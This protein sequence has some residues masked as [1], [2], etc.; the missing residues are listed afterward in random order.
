[1]ESIIMLALPVVVTI[2][3]QAVKTIQ[4]IKYSGNKGTILRFFAVTT[5]F[6]G[7]VLTSLA[8]GEGVG[9]EQISTYAET[10]LIFASTQVPYL[11]GKMKK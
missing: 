7:V 9:A 6:I 4:S 2:L 11:Y 5:T 8:T 3:T 10:I 1:M